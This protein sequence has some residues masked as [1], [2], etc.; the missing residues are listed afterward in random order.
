MA[1]YRAFSLYSSEERDAGRR[2]GVQSQRT[3]HPN[4]VIYALKPLIILFHYFG[5][6]L[7]CRRELKSKCSKLVK[8]QDIIKCKQLWFGSRR[9]KTTKTIK[10]RSFNRF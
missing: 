2:H 1:T 3:D 9:V 5:F 8:N 6:S 4:R 7:L 10:I